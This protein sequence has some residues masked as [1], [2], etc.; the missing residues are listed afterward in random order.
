MFK[1]QIFTILDSGETEEL[2]TDQKI[3]EIL[4]TNECYLIF[5]E[6]QKTIWLWK[7]LK[8]RIRSKFIAAKKS[9]E[10]RGQV[11]LMNKVISIDE[12]D[13][14]ERFLRS[15]GAPPRAGRVVAEEIKIEEM[16]QPAAPPSFSTANTSTN[17]QPSSQ[18]SSQP[19]AQPAAQPAPQPAPR[20]AAQPASQPAAQPAVQP[21]A[22]QNA[23]RVLG[24]L[25]NLKVPEGYQRE[26][27]II[28]NTAYSISKKEQIFLGKKKVE[29]T[30]EP[31]GSL[32]EGVFFA[33]GYAPR[34][35]V[36]NGVV[37][38]IEFL[39]KEAAEYSDEKVKEEPVSLKNHLAKSQKDLVS[40]L[41][42]KIKKE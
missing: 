12:D 8:A 42:F 6:D 20:P 3:S 40:S 11:G 17:S 4:N 9:Q 29:K 41:G 33:D 37:L 35:L 10:L 31:I 1:I 32:P 26:M 27:I 34:V 39:K 24:M 30:L 38:A 36:E 15:I 18:P 13:E 23:D 14:P 7:G 2:H 5:D 22:D 19:A 28:G 16:N 21:A 25:R